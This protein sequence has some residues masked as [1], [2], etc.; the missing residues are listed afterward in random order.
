MYRLVMKQNESNAFRKLHFMYCFACSVYIS[1][2]YETYS[3]HYLI[4]ILHY[5][6]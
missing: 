4:N 6:T 1:L 5:A 2:K 3:W